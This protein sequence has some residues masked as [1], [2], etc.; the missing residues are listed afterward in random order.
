MIIIIKS[1]LPI[2]EYRLRP[3]SLGPRLGPGL[4]M[5][6]GGWGGWGGVGGV[7]GGP[8]GGLVEI[9]VEAP[10]EAHYELAMQTFIYYFY[11]RFVLV[12]LEP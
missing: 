10:V 6:W 3:K 9:P 11:L 4:G 2:A 12:R 7:G 8:C 1:A 5:G